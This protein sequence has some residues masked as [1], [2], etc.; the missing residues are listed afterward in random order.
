MLVAAMAIFFCSKDYNPF[1]DLT[2]AKVHVTSWSFAGRDSVALFETGTFN[3]VVALRQEVDSF[4][5]HALKN[6]FGTDT[7]VRRP[8]AEKEIQGGPYSFQVSFFDTGSDTVTLTT[9]RSNG[10]KLSQDFPVR[11]YNPL[12]QENVTGNFGDTIVLLTMN[13]PD[14]DAVYH[15]NFAGESEV[16]SP[17]HRFSTSFLLFYPVAGKGTLW[18]SDHSN[19]TKSPAVAFSY[20]FGDTSKPQIRCVNGGM[21]ADTILSGDTVFAFKVLITDAGNAEVESCSVN[22]DTFDFEN[23]GTHVFTKIFKNLPDSIKNNIPLAIN[24][25]AL[26]SRKFPT[27]VS[28]HTFYVRYDPNG[29]TAAHSSVVFTIPKSES[30]STPKRGFTIY[31]DAQNDYGDTMRLFVRV[32]DKFNPSPKT[33]IGGGQWSWPVSLDTLI[34][35][36]TVAAYSV[37]GRLLASAQRIIMFDSI[38]IDSVKPMIWEVSTGGVALGNEVHTDKEALPLKIIAFDEGSGIASM[39]V[40]NNKLLVDSNSYEWNWPN[41]GLSHGRDT[42]HI[43]VTDAK[44]NVQERTITIFR[45]SIPVIVG[46]I[47][48]P[49]QGCAD[50]AYTGR[51]SLYDGDRD[52][53]DLL[54]IKHSKDITIKLTPADSIISWNPVL[55]ADSSKDTL[56]LQLEDHY[57]KNSYQWI[58]TS[59]ACKQS[60]TS[61]AFTTREQDFPGVLQAGV[62]SLN[63]RLAVTTSGFS[64]IPPRYYAAFLDNGDRLLDY[65]TSSLLS[66]NPLPSD[67]GYRRLIVTVG[68]S[69]HAYDTLF[70]AIRVVPR[71]QYSCSLSALFSGDT[72]F[73][74]ELD[75]FSH[76][77]PETLFFT[78]H[79][80]DNPLTEA[81]IVSIS[82]HSLRSVET[83]DK[84][85]FFVAI[86]PDTSRPADTLLV[87][88]L[89][90][91]GFTD[92][93]QFIMRNVRSNANN[94]PEFLSNYEFPTDFCA[95][96]SSKFKIGY[97]DR[98]RDIVGFR[99][100]YAPS[101]MVI[102]NQSVEGFLELQWKPSKLKLGMDSLVLQLFDQHD[103]S[104]VR[105]WQLSVIDCANK[106]PA[107]HFQ[108]DTG[109]FPKMLQADSDVVSL[110][111]ITAPGT[112]AKPFTFNARLDNGS[113][114]LH[115]DTTGKL[116][117]KPL[118]ADTGMRV[119]TISV[120][121]HYNTSDNI[122][123]Q[124]TIVPRNRHPCSLKFLS[125][126]GTILPSGLLAM[127]STT[128]PESAQVAII[129]DDNRLTE[130][131]TETIK[132]SNSALITLGLPG[133][134]QSFAVKINPYSAAL[135]SLLDTTTVS[136]RDKTGATPSVKLIV[137]YPIRSPADIPQLS[138]SLSSANAETQRRG[139]SV[140]R[141]SD[142]VVNLSQ[143]DGDRQPTLV[144]NAVNGLP[145][146]HF[147]HVTHNGDDGLFDESYGQW[148]NDPFTVFVVFSASSLSANS[149]QTLVSTNTTD[150]FGVGIACNGNIGIFNDASA[151]NCVT[152]GWASTDLTVAAQT[153][154]VASFK[155]TLGMTSDRNIRVQAWLSGI[156]ASQPMEMTTQS[157]PGLAIGTGA[158]D[159]DG[160]FD[161][162]I[163]AIAIYRQALSDDDRILVEKYFGNLYGIT[164]R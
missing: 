24:V 153:W 97:R 57:D 44:N 151:N 51:L 4:A 137:H 145:A 47:G 37:D 21:I 134:T 156:P 46:D 45:N 93:L 19:K 25:W 143:M 75:L 80:K 63:I 23:R 49:A 73:T 99:T 116:L 138:V 62:D 3:V 30:V 91:T 105:R 22:Q 108:T 79:D 87:T 148:A 139:N 11:V 9:F 135:T 20:A 103:S 124:F 83:I 119:M 82:L 86:G 154:Y 58:F 92:S 155:S 70:P 90:K 149:R 101:G 146:V 120:N 163:A 60:S 35:T 7:I 157:D 85:E 27:N 106:P 61:I 8:S 128:Q 17:F 161:G 113:Y 42:V 14:N 69:L 18:V 40:N 142:G 2:N 16:S 76:P 117:W 127:F 150:G 159:Y 50:S 71:N 84:K 29:V 54:I 152:D 164:I 115:D 41:G 96:T 39:V 1:T 52:P 34:T 126:S 32:N 133:A 28:R 13:V 64:S 132:R 100:I 129:D 55:R 31:G 121:D 125:Y 141:W 12:Q 131:Y 26:D 107:V 77:A 6:R 123:P 48:I 158:T 56:I 33:I 65:D 66:W 110:Q 160:S 111:L 81:Y 43:I 112:G 36:V 118:S 94:P 162:S 122:S 98:D 15:W 53:V 68:D 104:K 59:K 88:V 102:S 140:S 95:D 38:A 89:D 5:F 147:D 67:T 114:I 10:E 130:Q 109:D 144:P 74:G 78:I 136:V 72:T